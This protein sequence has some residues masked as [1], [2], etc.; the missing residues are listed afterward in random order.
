LH[1]NAFDDD[2]KKGQIF[3]M[4]KMVNNGISF[5]PTSLIIEVIAIL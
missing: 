3:I 4:W 2:R 5:H 1:E